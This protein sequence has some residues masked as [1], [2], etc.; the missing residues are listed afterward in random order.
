MNRVPLRRPNIAMPSKLRERVARPPK[1][2][3]SPTPPAD[4]RAPA[5][6]Q[7]LQKHWPWWVTLL[8]ALALNYLFISVFFPGQPQRVEVSYTFFKQQVE[9]DN[10]AEISSR[11]DTIQGHS[12]RGRPIHRTPDRGEDGPGLLHHAAGVCRPGLET[13]LNAHGV[14]INARPVDE[15]RSPLLTLL[16][17]FGPTIL[18]I[19]AFL[20]LTKRAAA[21]AGG[22]LFGMGKS[23]AKRYDQTAAGDNK[24]TF[25][26]VAGIDEAKAELVEIVDFLKDPKK[27]TRLGGTAPKGVLLVEQYGN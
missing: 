11:A 26:D 19:G 10:V 16:L 4:Q 2:R 6:V 8:V 18:L 27:Y 13:L 23:Q 15:A 9:A 22:G 1:A 5:P 7:H 17:S 14:I 20:W 25:A 12:V 3:T 24:V 21:S